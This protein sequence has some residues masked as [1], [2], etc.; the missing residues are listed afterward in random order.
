L[1][2]QC[3][4][5]SLSFQEELKWLKRIRTGWVKT[6]FEFGIYSNGLAT[7]VKSADFKYMMKSTYSTPVY[8]DNEEMISINY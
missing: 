6:R 7:K 5:T 3:H 4:W 1:P 8:T 2:Q